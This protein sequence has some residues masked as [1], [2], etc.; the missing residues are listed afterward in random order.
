MGGCGFGEVASELIMRIGWQM[1]SSEPA[2]VMKYDTASADELRE[3]IVKFGRSMQ[4]ELRSYAL[5]EPELAG[6]GTTW[7]CAYLM[8]HDAIIAHV[9]DSRA[10]HFRTGNLQRLTRDHTFAQRLQDAG[11]PAEDTTRFKHLLVNSFAADPA[12]VKIDIDHI[13]LQIGDRLLLCSDG[14]TGMVDDEEIVATLAGVA[15]PQAAA[16]ALIEQALRNG[17]KDNVTVVI[18]D[19]VDAPL[20]D[21]SARSGNPA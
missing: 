11:V 21:P 13:A 18:A 16:D 19:L 12:D 5:A 15:N 10:Y 20:S 9:G 8:G 17:G 14:L 7:T 6:M 4:N 2:W 1:A 3:R